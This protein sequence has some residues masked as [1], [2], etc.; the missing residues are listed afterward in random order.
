VA[1]PTNRQTSSVAYASA[2]YDP[3]VGARHGD[4]GRANMALRDPSAR[5][6]NV[7]PREGGN[8]TSVVKAVLA[9]LREMLTRPTRA[10]VGQQ[11]AHLSVQVPHKQPARDPGDLARVTVKQTVTEASAG[12]DVGHMRAAAAMKALAYDPSDVARVTVKQTLTEASAGSDVGHMRAAVAKKALVYDPNDIAR[13]TIK[14]TTPLDQREFARIDGGQD[15]RGGQGYAATLEGMHNPESRKADLV[16]V[17]DAR[18]PDVGAARGAQAGGY[19]TET[20][21]APAT[22]R[23]EQLASHVGAAA[24]APEGLKFRSYEDVYNALVSDLKAS[25][26]VQ[27]EPTPQ[28]AKVTDGADALRVTTRRTDLDATG[29]VNVQPI[30]GGLE[31]APPLAPPTTTVALRAEERDP[32]AERLDAALLTAYLSNPLVKPLDSVA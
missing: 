5:R 6:P 15:R 9:P 28:S 27:R 20:H 26:L 19:Q 2:A 17:Q 11:Q 23:Q 12:R 24:A 32:D 22:H 21:S 25:A 18:G 1:K 30:A 10:V 13:T 14:Q 29:F 7:A 3:S 4:Y 31:P 8:L 16:A